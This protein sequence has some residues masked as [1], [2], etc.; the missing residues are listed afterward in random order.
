MAAVKSDHSFLG[1]DGAA[2]ALFTPPQ[3]FL[4]H[5]C[6]RSVPPT[7]SLLPCCQRCNILAASGIASVFMTVRCCA[8]QDY[9][10]VLAADVDAAAPLTP[11]QPPLC[12]RSSSCRIAPAP[13]FLA[14]NTA[15]SVSSVVH[16]LRGLSRQPSSYHCLRRH[17][18]HSV[19]FTDIVASSLPTIVA[20]I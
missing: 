7:L 20:E 14:A 8:G 4:R 16:Y 18:H 9:H 3:L 17:S 15:A 6:S 5:H 10:R 1:A 2:A 13:T 12:R 11:P 19:L